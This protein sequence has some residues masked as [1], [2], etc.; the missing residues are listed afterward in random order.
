MNIARGLAIV[1]LVSVS[2]CGGG[3]KDS[4][5]HDLQ[6]TTPGAPQARGLML[7]DGSDSVSGTV[8]PF[9]DSVSG[10]VGRT[11]VFRVGKGTVSYPSITV[12]CRDAAGNVIPCILGVIAGGSGTTS[13]ATSADSVSGTTGRTP[14][15]TTE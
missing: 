11:A 3:T 4:E 12:V 15:D 1:A 2:G 14:G 13:N 7:S 9:V 8:V 5:P 10:T 6:S